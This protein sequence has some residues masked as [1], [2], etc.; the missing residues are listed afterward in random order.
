MSEHIVRDFFDR[1]EDEQ[2]EF[3]KFT[4]CNT[5]QE[6]DLG[7]KNPREYEMD[8]TVYIEGDCLQ[9]GDTVT[10]ELQFDEDE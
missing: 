4:W 9:C 6:V 1:A 8:G 5:C 3:L 10:T 2:K 7:M